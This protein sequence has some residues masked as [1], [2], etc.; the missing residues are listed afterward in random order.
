MHIQ[1]AGKLIEVRP[2]PLTDKYA[3]APDGT[4]YKRRP[5]LR[6]VARGGE[7][8][9]G[10]WEVAHL[11][12]VASAYT[13]P[14]FRFSF[15]VGK[16]RT[17]KTVHRFVLECFDGVRDRSAVARHKNDDHLDNR[18]ENLAYGSVQ[19][20]VDDAIA[21]NGNYAEGSRNGR[22][23]LNEREVIAIRKR[24]ASGEAVDCVARD[25]PHLSRLSIKNAGY[26]VTWS[27]LP[28]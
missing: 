9:Y 26:G 15:T 18:I 11:F 8:A 24:I 16:K 21:N 28:R 1:V 6:G 4:V 25:Y 14:Y 12:P 2:H 10:E 23:K 13:P 17:L 22:A 20:N 19:D 3:A 7:T 5:T 27:H